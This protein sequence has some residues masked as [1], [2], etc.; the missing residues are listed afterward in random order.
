MAEETT[1]K[2]SKEV[3]EV[4]IEEL[5]HTNQWL[6]EAFQ[7]VKNKSLTLIGGALATLTF[8]YSSGDIFFPGEVYGRIFYFIGLGAL[9]IGLGL[10]CLTLLPQRWEFSTENKELA[11]LEQKNIVKYLE[12]VKDRHL[13]SYRSNMRTYE[14]TQVLV[15]RGF[16]ALILGAIILVI[17]KIF[18]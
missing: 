4:A 7:R 5:R 8:L 9:L 18:A 16:H 10:L 12:Y 11:K 1:Q 2:P 17:L 14:H 6:S 13:D 3:L 15:M